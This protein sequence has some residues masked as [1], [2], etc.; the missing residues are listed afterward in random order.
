M[1]TS[2]YFPQRC[3]LVTVSHRFS[4][5]HIFLSP[6]VSYI[7]FLDFQCLPVPCSPIPISPE[8]MFPYPIWLNKFGKGLLGC[9]WGLG[10]RVT[11]EYCDVDIG[12]GTEQ[13]MILYSKVLTTKIQFWNIRNIFILQQLHTMMCKHHG[14]SNN[15]PLDCLFNSLFSPMSKETYKFGIIGHFIFMWRCRQSCRLHYM[16][17]STVRLGSIIQYDTSIWYAVCHSKVEIQ[18]S[19]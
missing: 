14:M 19:K 13:T 18:A 2:L 12:N 5:D 11:R 15:W 8:A 17:W 10:R 1:S 3:F 9:T 7:I 4:S 6:H 16:K